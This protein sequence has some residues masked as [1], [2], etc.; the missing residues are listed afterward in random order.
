MVFRF[1]HTRGL[2]LMTNDDLSLCE[3]T[4]HEV[5]PTDHD[6]LLSNGF[7]EDYRG[8]WT[9]GRSTRIDISKYKESKTARRLSKRCVITFGDNVIDDDV[10][11][12][13]ESYCK[14][15][16]FDRMIPIDAYSSC[17]QLRIYV[18]GILRSVTFMSDVSE[19]MV[20]YQFISDYER[21]D[22][23]LGS[24]SQMMECL[25]AR[26]H[27]AQYLY[28]GFGYEE[29]CLYKTRIHGLEW[30][31]GSVWS[32]DMSKLISLMNGD[33]MLPNCYQITGYAQN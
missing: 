22:L 29:S 18:D 13:Y 32:S 21:A 31:T 23:S 19:N 10:I 7:C 33:S 20:S 8:F 15:K 12:V 24:V 4:A 27:G 6:W 28:I 2:G 25:F 26:Q 16:G 3:V 30:W 9:Q 1:D 17:N 11:R 5:L 14:H